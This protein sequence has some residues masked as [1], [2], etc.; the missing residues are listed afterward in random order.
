MS[1]SPYI[2]YLVTIRTYIEV[3]RREWN[4]ARKNKSLYCQRRPTQEVETSIGVAPSTLGH[5]EEDLKGEHRDEE[6]MFLIN[7]A[8]DHEGEYKVETQLS[9]FASSTSEHQ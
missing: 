2:K 1:T 9:A 5:L 6:P 3:V 4:I 8:R 7:S